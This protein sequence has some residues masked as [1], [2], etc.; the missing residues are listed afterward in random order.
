MIL[1]RLLGEDTNNCKSMK[2][3]DVFFKHEEIIN[4]FAWS[5]FLLPTVEIWNGSRDVPMW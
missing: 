5:L 4:D 3:H 2:N 1:E